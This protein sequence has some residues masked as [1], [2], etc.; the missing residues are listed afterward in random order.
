MFLTDV[1]L[2]FQRFFLICLLTYLCGCSHSLIVISIAKTYMK[3]AFSGT[4]R[5]DDDTLGLVLHNCRRSQGAD[6]TGIT[7]STISTK[8]DEDDEDA[9]LLRQ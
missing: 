2:L 1:L 8:E 3:K 6:R 4:R 7:M 5:P 9:K